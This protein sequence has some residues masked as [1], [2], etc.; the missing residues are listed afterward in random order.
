MKCKRRNR[1]DYLKHELA[2]VESKNIGKGT[3]VW[4]FA[5]ILPEAVIGE[6]CN[7]CD[8]TFIENDV[9]IG[10]RV[11]VKCGVYIWDGITLEDD[12]FV[13]PNVTFTNDKHPR[14]KHYQQEVLNTIVC[15][16]ASIG[17]NATILPG[18]TI[19]KNVMIGAGAVVTKSVP[20]NAIVTGNP[21]QI[22]GYTVDFKHDRSEIIDFDYKEKE[23]PTKVRLIKLPHFSD[24]R[25]DISVIEFDDIIPFPVKRSFH[26][27]GTN[28]EH[29]RGEHAHKECHQLL[30]AVNGS[31]NVV[32]E[33][34]KH[35]EEFTLDRPD[36]A[37]Y[38]PP[39]LWA[40]QYK[41]S[42]DAILLVLASHCYDENDY[43]R[44]YDDFIKF[45]DTKG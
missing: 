36:L 37:L 30:I 45:I 4:A 23:Y 39:R 33:N 11:T 7:I 29:V 10:N 2:L 3:R 44:D 6:N 31:L 12:V 28:N 42:L 13:G 1:M 27:Y 35:S 18:I 22:S 41:H 9:V 32:I 43:I 5:H 15:Q 24:V 25:G 16:G 17:A 40:V 20:A 34:G 26:V 14:S 19:G 8:H 38:I 21:A